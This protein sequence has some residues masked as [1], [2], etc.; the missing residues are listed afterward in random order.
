MRSLH[1]RQLISRI[2]EIHGGAIV[3]SPYSLFATVEEISGSISQQDVEYLDSAFRVLRH[4]EEPAAIVIRDRYPWGFAVHPKDI[5]YE[6]SFTYQAA[7]EYFV[8]FTEG[9]YAVVFNTKLDT[10]NMILDTGV[11]PYLVAAPGYGDDVLEELRGKIKLVEFDKD[12]LT[13]LR[14]SDRHD[15]RKTLC[16]GS[17]S[18]TRLNPII[19]KSEGELK[20]YVLSEK[21]PTDKELRD[22][23]IAYWLSANFPGAFMV[24][25][26]CMVANGAGFSG[27]QSIS[28]AVELSKKHTETRHTYNLLDIYSTEGSSMA[29]ERITSAGMIIAAEAGV[30]AILA[31]DVADDVPDMADKYDISLV[32]LPV[33]H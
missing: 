13:E 12:R 4:A 25:D 19:F 17:V 14:K 9:D 8:A 31:H 18:V 32:K 6:S 30:K 29:V 21:E 3:V 20:K 28:A 15:D 23:Q 27:D 10:T 2:R 16:D 5:D 7:T 1:E 33:K 24:R 11:K 26:G 22:L